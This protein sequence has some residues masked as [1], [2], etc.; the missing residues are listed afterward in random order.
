M[1][2]G[3]EYF[4]VGGGVGI[5]YDGSQSNS[6][7]S[8][9]YSLEDYIADVVYILKDIC[10]LHKVKHPNIVTETG[11]AVCAHHSCVITKAFG[12]VN[13]TINQKIETN[14]HP[15]DHHL[16]KNIKECFHDLNEKNFQEVYND[17]SMIKDEIT[18]AFKLGVI[19]LEERSIAESIYWSICHNILNITRDKDYVT[20]EI[21][22]LKTTLSDKYLCNF[23]IFQSA[24]DTWAINQILPV[25]PISRHNEKP[26]HSCTIA[27]ITC[28]SDGK[29]SNF[30]GPEE[31]NST[32]P[33]HQLVK[34][35]DYFLGLFLTG[36][37]QDV[38]G[39]MHNMF[40]RLNEVHIFCDDDDPT[41]FYIE[42]IIHGNSAAEVLS[43]M[44]YNPTELC[45]KVKV[46]IDSNIKQGKIK[47]RSGV[48]LID[49]YEACLN[50]YTY[51]N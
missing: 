46:D 21:K 36:A 7:S 27:D 9:N 22:E 19:N 29:I 13:L 35:E 45:R 32:L 23:S 24:P 43:I 15:D 41:D 4:D 8:T 38:M 40:G 1:G 28:D 37:Y 50:S 18:S 17:I 26:S 33:V 12:E 51:L 25:V 10:D 14:H 39:D 16:I 2:V 31:I 30:L 48:K 5:N 20:N 6:F 47:P 49:F 44:Q 42:E 34:G 3:L 11:R